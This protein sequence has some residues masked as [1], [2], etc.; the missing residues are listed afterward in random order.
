MSFWEE[1]LI[2]GSTTQGSFKPLLADIISGKAK[3]LA[4]AIS[5]KVSSCL[6]L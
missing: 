5:I 6:V 3:L 4:L 1:V 2:S